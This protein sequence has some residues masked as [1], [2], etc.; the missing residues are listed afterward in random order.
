[1]PEV[2]NDLFE[3]KIIEIRPENDGELWE[4]EDDSMGMIVRCFQSSPL[5]IVFSNGCRK[6]LSETSLASGNNRTYGEDLIHGKNGWTRLYPPVE[7]NSV[8][9]I[10]IE[11]VKNF[12]FCGDTHD[13][14][15]Y[16]V[17]IPDGHLDDLE[18]KPP[19]KMILEIPKEEI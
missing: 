15:L 7:D 6:H 14:S 10:E 8:E 11:G 4:H 16:K 3:A 5:E 18:D 13:A 9:R 12:R 17:D 19:M 1:L 2:K